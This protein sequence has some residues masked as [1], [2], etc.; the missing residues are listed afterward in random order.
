MTWRLSPVILSSWYNVVDGL[1]VHVEDRLYQRL[2][3]LGWL[4]DCVATFVMWE[5]KRLAERGLELAPGSLL[6]YVEGFRPGD[7][8]PADEPNAGWHTYTGLGTT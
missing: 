8:A 6:F 3:R 7:L 5:R 2:V 1:V 4:D